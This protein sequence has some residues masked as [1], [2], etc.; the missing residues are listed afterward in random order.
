MVFFL[1]FFFGKN[2]LFIGRVD[3]FKRKLCFII[4][5]SRHD[6]N[7]NMLTIIVETC[8]GYLTLL[9]LDVYLILGIKSLAYIKNFGENFQLKFF[10]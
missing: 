6:R 10:L 9:L 5:L 8:R 1:S 3:G 4:F 2:I 7:S